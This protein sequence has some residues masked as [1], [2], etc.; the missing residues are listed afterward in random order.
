MK[1][2]II[3]MFI[4]DDVRFYITNMGRLIKQHPVGGYSDVTPDLTKVKKE[5]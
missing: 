5:N 2:K 4:R 3:Q 1:E